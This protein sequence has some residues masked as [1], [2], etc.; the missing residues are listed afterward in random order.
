MV[1]VNTHERDAAERVLDME[2]TLARLGGD[3]QLLIEMATFLLEDAPPLVYKIREAVAADNGSQ[4]ESSAHALKG[5]LM[6]SGG[7]RAAKVVQALEDAG[8]H[9]NT[10]HANS[11]LPTLDSELELLVAAIRDHLVP[12]IQSAASFPP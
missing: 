11:L 5:L 1:N 12:G 7:V 9:S 8:R 6:N 10:L 4:L 3:R 2:S